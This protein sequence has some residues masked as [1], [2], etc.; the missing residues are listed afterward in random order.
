MARVKFSTLLKAP[1]A[2]LYDY[3]FF[4]YVLSHMDISGNDTVLDIGCGSGI[5]EHI[6]EDEVRQVIGI[7]ISSETIDLL[8]QYNTAD[9]V[10]Y[11]SVDV[12]NEIPSDLIGICDKIV[13]IN[14]LEHVLD[15]KNAI[16]FISKA[17]KPGGTGYVAFPVNNKCHGN[18][19]LQDNVPILFSD[20]ATSHELTYIYLRDRDSP[21]SRIF[22]IFR[23][24]F[25]LCEADDFK[26]TVSFKLFRLQLGNIIIKWVYNMTKL[27]ILALS[28]IGNKYQRTDINGNCCL[29][30]IRER[31]NK[32]AH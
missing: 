5:V 13:C 32:D 16:R 31:Q 11:R 19:I 3:T 4:R 23:G 7:D 1:M 28:Y 8:K 26:V 2:N 20:L 27:F 15:A 29:V 9:N 10:E 12:T 30:M 18:L 17:L 25:P 14:V 21:I 6:L 22:R 24:L